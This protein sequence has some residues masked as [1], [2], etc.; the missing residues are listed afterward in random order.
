LGVVRPARAARGFESLPRHVETPVQFLAPGDAFMARGQR[1]IVR[2]VIRKGE[3]R[4][5]LV[6]GG[7]ED[8]QPFDATFGWSEIIDTLDP[9]VKL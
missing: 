6:M 1:H 2:H 8:G 5:V 3:T 4:E 7:R 9:A